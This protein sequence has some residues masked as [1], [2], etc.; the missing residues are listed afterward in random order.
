MG[1]SSLRKKLG[2]IV[3]V[4]Y[5][6]AIWTI[7]DFEIA[8]YRS[9]ETA[10]YLL[11]KQLSKKYA[12]DFPL[13]DI[14]YSIYWKKVHPDKVM[15]KQTFP[16]LE[17]S[18]IISDLLAAVGEAPLIGI[19]PKLFK[20]FMKGKESIVHYLQGIKHELFNLENYEPSDIAERLPMYFASDL[21]NYLTKKDSVLP[22]IFFDTYEALWES[23]RTEA[24]YLTQDDWVRELVGHLPEV[25]WIFCG[26]E[27]LRWAEKDSDWDRYLEQHLIGKLS[28]FDSRSFL[29]SCGIL[30]NEVKDTIIQTSDGLPYYLDLAVDTYE[31]IRKNHFRNPVKEDFAETT[32]DVFSRF[33]KYLDQHEIE[34]LKVLS[35]PRFFDFQLYKSLVQ[36]FQTGYPITSFDELC[37]F[38]FM[39]ET[40]SPDLWYIHQLMRNSLQECQSTVLL[41]DVHTFV[42][43]YYSEKIKE[44]LIIKQFDQEEK[45][46]LIEAVYHAKKVLNED[47]LVLWIE[48][49]TEPYIKM[50][51]YTFIAPIYEDMISFIESKTSNPSTIYRLVLTLA[52]VRC[53]GRKY[54]DAKPTIEKALSLTKLCLGNDHPIVAEIFVLFAEYFY[55]YENDMKKAEDYYKQALEIQERYIGEDLETAVTYNS[56]AIFYTFIGQY[57]LSEQ[58]YRKAYAIRKARLGEPHYLTSASINNIGCV[59]LRKNQPEEGLPYL[60]RALQMI[61]DTVGENTRR[62]VNTYHS[63]GNAHFM[64][65]NFDKAEEIFNQ[66]I[67]MKVKVYPPSHLEVARLSRDFGKLY[68]DTNRWKKAIPHFEAAITVMENEFGEDNMHH[69]DIYHEFGKLYAMMGEND[70][71]KTL[72]SKAITIHQR[73][74]GANHDSIKAI[75]LDLNKLS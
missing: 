6:H 49:V 37:R 62:Y 4:E 57:N 36:N 52:K 23:N 9:P 16:L 75:E 10:L 63:I 38:S 21:K 60:E 41:Q 28:D 15:N 5:D 67:E 13:F 73:V 74:L 25:L 24:N 70:L 30:D 27:K 54:K 20:S 2:Q 35:V 72:Y 64:L 53:A 48:K 3:D 58:F 17:E 11:R 45:M 22:I 7:L 40:E 68:R 46:V 34:T 42:Y 44:E 26:R 51:K 71:A 32:K 69:A 65:G 61:K 39:N 43:K 47:D 14:A 33:M 19:V 8:N 12:I 56:L 50:S 59:K 1:K 31:N 55:R 66:L 18:H 29:N